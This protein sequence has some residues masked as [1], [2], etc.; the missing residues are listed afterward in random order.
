[1]SAEGNENKQILLGGLKWTNTLWMTAEQWM[2]LALSDKL[3][4]LHSVETNQCLPFTGLYVLPRPHTYLSEH[5]CFHVVCPLKL[6][7]QLP[8]SHANVPL[9][10]SVRSHQHSNFVVSVINSPL[11]FPSCIW[12]SRRS[13]VTMQLLLMSNTNVSV[14]QHRD[15]YLPLTTTRHCRPLALIYSTSLM[16]PCPYTIS[17]YVLLN[18]FNFVFESGRTFAIV[19]EKTHLLEY[20]HKLWCKLAI[21]PFRDRGKNIL[22]NLFIFLSSRLYLFD[23]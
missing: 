19:K 23:S 18:T 13:S 16:L 9:S 21:S 10:E 4:S 5:E 14:L 1:M 17:D 15:L 6:A 11:V 20:P 3:L 8:Q 22:R 12:C 2:Y 7:V